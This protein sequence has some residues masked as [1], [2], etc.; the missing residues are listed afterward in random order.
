MATRKE[1]AMLQPVSQGR[2][3]K[4]GGYFMSDEA[5]KAAKYDMI[6]KLRKTREK[7][8]VLR[9]QAKEIGKALEDFG[10]IL[11]NPSWKLKVEDA[12]IIG[13]AEQFRGVSSATLTIKRS[14]LSDDLIVRLILELESTE[15]DLE[16]Q[17]RAVKD[18]AI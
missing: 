15:K 2:N 16:E 18:L 11:A 10:M 17:S 9:D 12:E 5:E 3:L 13:K 4:R 8:T 1:D 7:L 6:V 14:Y